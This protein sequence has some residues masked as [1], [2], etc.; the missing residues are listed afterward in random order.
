[1]IPVTSPLRIQSGPSCSNCFIFLF[2]LKTLNSF[3]SLVNLN[4]LN[5]RSISKLPS[6]SAGLGMKN[7]RS[8]NGMVEIKSRKNQVR[9]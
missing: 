1:L 7:T 9:M 3:N 2:A 6:P 5:N 4:T 8:S